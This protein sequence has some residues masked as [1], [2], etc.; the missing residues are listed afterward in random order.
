MNLDE[1]RKDSEK[2]DL[3]DDSSLKSKQPLTADFSSRI[4]NKSQTRTVFRDYLF[5]FIIGFK[6][7]IKGFLPQKYSQK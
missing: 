5:M 7:I 1:K 4:V 6:E 2:K 3:W